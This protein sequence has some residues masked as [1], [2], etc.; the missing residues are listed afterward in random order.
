MKNL[1]ILPVTLIAM[2]LVFGLKIGTVWTDAQ[3]LFLDLKVPEVQA[4][5]ANDTT[6]DQAEKAEGAN[7]AAD[8]AAKPAGSGQ[9]AA[10]APS[11]QPQPVSAADL[12]ASEIEVLQRLVERRDELDRRD[13]ELDMRD[14]L[15]KATEARIDD[16]IARL[17]EI[18]ATIQDLLKKHDEQEEQKLLSLVSIYEKMKPKDAARIFNTLDMSVLLDVSA[19]MKEAK[20][21]GIL[22]KM[23]DERAKMLTV[24]LATRKQLPQVDSKEG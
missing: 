1:R 19:M 4:Q 10:A 5:A 8:T 17:K 23:D 14:N 16:K 9:D 22:A 13:K 24:E 2:V 11:G 6:S 15:L 18:E 20:L 3:G 12:S 7:R 21:A